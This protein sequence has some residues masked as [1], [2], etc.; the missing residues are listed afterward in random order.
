MS[1]IKEQENLRSSEGQLT[2]KNPCCHQQAIKEGRSRMLPPEHALRLAETFKI[3]GDINRIH[4]INI[5]TEREM[6]VHE[7]ST[8]LGM[9]SSAVS[10]QLRLLRNL[11]LVKH[12]KEGKMVYYSLDDSHIFS[13][14]KEGLEHIKH[15]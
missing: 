3:L 5:L 6:C 7:L 15:T 11:R 13:L 14:F 9:T 8:V 4:L 12:R 10:H 1:T 2:Y